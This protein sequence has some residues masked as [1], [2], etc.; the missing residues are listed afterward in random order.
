MNPSSAMA[1]ASIMPGHSALACA[2]AG[3]AFVVVTDIAAKAAERRR[4]RFV[5]IWTSP[6]SG[7][8]MAFS[9]GFSRRWVCGPE[10][11]HCPLQR[12]LRPLALCCRFFRPVEA[13][14]HGERPFW[15]RQPVGFLVLAGGFV[16]DNQRQSAVGI[17]L[18]LRQHR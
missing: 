5:S 2:L 10:P 15:C 3:T 18:E 8:G 11:L 14:D 6:H 1:L 9:S 7:T 17:A 13:H 12:R 4:S 16:L